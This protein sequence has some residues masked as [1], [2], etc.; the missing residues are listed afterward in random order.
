MYI[1]ST[2][3]VTCTTKGATIALDSS[4]GYTGNIVCPDITKVC[5]TYTYQSYQTFA[6]SS[7][8]P[9]DNVATGTTP[10][11]TATSGSTTS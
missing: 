6:N 2:Y 7:Y 8:F 1:T 5:T 11:S 3:S 10:S 4:Q 9:Y